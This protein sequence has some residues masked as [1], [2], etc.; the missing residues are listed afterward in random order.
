MA[1]Q[2]REASSMQSQTS[3][4]A[5]AVAMANGNGHVTLTPP[6]VVGGKTNN[7]SLELRHILKLDSP[8]A[9]ATTTTTTTTTATTTSEDAETRSSEAICVKEPD[10][11]T[12][13][14]N[15]DLTNLSDRKQQLNDGSSQETN[16]IQGQDQIP[17]HFHIPGQIPDSDNYGG[18]DGEGGG[19]GNEGFHG[20]GSCCGNSNDALISPAN[21]PVTAASPS[22]KDAK[23]AE[24][25]TSKLSDESAQLHDEVTES[26]KSKS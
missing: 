18:G 10:S 15:K 20:D 11:R 3:E 19:Y 23:S 8:A 9:T 14:A 2:R 4:S 26:Q 13:K 5:G 24:V 6:T 1:I 7:C 22:W 12:A 21:T 17:R 16:L 25:S